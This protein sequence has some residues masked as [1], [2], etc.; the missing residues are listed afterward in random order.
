MKGFIFSLFMICFSLSSTAQVPTQEE[1][2]KLI[3]QAQQI[4][5]KANNQVN[6]QL[7]KNNIPIASS[8][9]VDTAVSFTANSFAEYCNTWK[10]K[11]MAKMM[12]ADEK[13]KAASQAKLINPNEPLRTNDI[14]DQSSAGAMMVAGRDYANLGVYLIFDAG[15]L[16]PSNNITV[17]NV[18]GLLRMMDL[19]PEAVKVFLYANSID[20]NSLII[21]TQLG[22]SLLEYGDDKKAEFYF[23]RCFRIDEDYPPAHRGMAAVY[24]KRGMPADAYEEML[25]GASVGYNLNVGRTAEETKGGCGFGDENEDGTGGSGFPYER[26]KQ[27]IDRAS[28]YISVSTAVVKEQSV[29]HIPQFPKFTSPDDYCQT[30]AATYMPLLMENMGNEKKFM[31]IAKSL[32][33]ANEN[34]QYAEE[35]FMF[36]SINDI[37]HALA[38]KISGKYNKEK[39]DLEERANKELLEYGKTWS[40]NYEDCIKKCAKAEDDKCLKNCFCTA[41]MD[42]WHNHQTNMKGLF[43]QWKSLTI[44]LGDDLQ[45]L[46]NDYYKSSSAWMDRVYDKPMY[47]RMDLTRAGFSNQLIYIFISGLNFTSGFCDGPNTNMDQWCAGGYEQFSAKDMQLE[48]H[49]KNKGPECPKD[50]T[51]QITF[52]K[53]VSISLECDA[54]GVE[55]FNANV[56]TS[57]WVAGKYNWKKSQLTTI[58]G[59]GAAVGGGGFTSLGSAKI[60]IINVMDFKTNEVD[61]GVVGKLDYADAGMLDGS[62]SGYS[63]E[64][65]AM[66]ISGTEVSASKTAWYG[67]DG[68]MLKYSSKSKTP[69]WDQIIK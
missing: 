29:M 13:I 38:K 45:K 10:T 15:S 8:G 37:Y 57:P 40:S 67:N 64:A 34:P 6:K 19:V 3:K 7:P 51:M 47:E 62:K 5:N 16:M 69:G 25:R 39:L 46:Q 66:I 9:N 4:Q 63:M 18:G 60:G 59:V 61:G 28:K 27:S 49:E 58:A 42:I 68:L 22:N 54:V 48:K 26:V 35:D 50:K 31:D 43:Q 33:G 11:W 21:L 55:Y 65:K 17:N 44:N 24:L 12:R 2:Q 1:I 23:K 20:P 36:G 32:N 30:G 56:A 52:G 53:M 41:M 14:L